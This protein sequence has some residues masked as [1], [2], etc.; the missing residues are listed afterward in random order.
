MGSL[1][2]NPRR[3]AVVIVAVGAIITGLLAWGAQHQYDRNET[4]ELTLRVREAA[5]VLAATHAAIQASLA[6]AAQLA[7]THADRRALLAAEVGPGRLL[8]A[9]SVWPLGSATPSVVVGAPLE[10]RPAAAEALFA[11]AAGTGGLEVLSVPGSAAP[12]VGFAFVAGRFAA[13]GESALPASRRLPLAPGAAFSDLKYALYLGP[14][15]ATGA[16][17]L[18]SE[19]R[20]PLRGRRESATVPFGTQP[21]TIV[22]TPRRPLSGGLAQDLSWLVG[23]AGELLSIGAAALVLR[24]AGRRRHGE[25]LTERLG[26]LA[27]ENRR[28]RG[29]AR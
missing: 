29:D 17:L 19:R 15:P 7:A 8:A 1:R 23:L 24:F 11:R 25:Q 13:Y 28:L 3:A 12:R 21:M 27:Q 26:Q 16:A 4:R 22:M 9:L 10:V 2:R 18:S 20:L 6:G 5:T 14:R